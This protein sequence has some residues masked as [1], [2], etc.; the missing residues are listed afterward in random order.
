ML[1]LTRA[2]EE[3]IM[4]GDDIEVRVLDLRGDRVRLG[5]VAPAQVPIHRTEVYLAIQRENLEASR[6]D[7]KA[8]T[9]ALRNLGPR[10]GED[11]A[12][13]NETADRKRAERDQ[14]EQ[15]DS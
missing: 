8:A 9:D 12:G 10:P 14:G 15:T 6:V 4:I 7:P 5:I 11:G 1:V 3:G 13:S 2:R